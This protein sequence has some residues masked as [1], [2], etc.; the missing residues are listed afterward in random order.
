MKKMKL[1]ASL[2]ALTV[3]M[4]GSHEARAYGP[5]GMFGGRPAPDASIILADPIELKNDRPERAESVLEHPR[6][7][8]DATPYTL[9][10]FEIFPTVEM[11]AT[12]DSNIYATKS[13]PAADLVNTIR[14][15][16]NAFSNWGRH[17]LSMTT[18]GDINLF[19]DHSHENYENFVTDWNGRYDIMNQTWASVRAGYQH[20]AEPR[21]SADTADGT[22]PTTFSV[23]KGGATFYRGL[24]KVK[25]NVDY[26]VKRFD[27]NDSYST[28]TGSIDQSYRDRTE[29]RAGGQ[30]RYD[31]SENFKPF[32]RA[33]Y[34]QHDFDNNET[35]NST[36]YDAAVGAIADLGGVTSI[37]LYAGWLSASYDKSLVKKEV[38]APLVG[39]RIEWNPTG[40]TSVVLEGTRTVEDT[41]L[42][43]FSGYIASGGS[44]TITHELRRNILIEGNFG[45]TRSD[46]EGQGKR[47]DDDYAMGPGVRYL[48]N[49]NI[50]TDVSYNYQT[51]TSTVSTSEF[52][53]HLVMLRLGV[54][55]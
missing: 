18:F 4:I 29:H 24:G 39:G 54:K 51:R 13:K 46:Y 11:G 52:D 22:D 15:V 8:Y 7:D 45:L 16:V 44:A 42:T 10:S 47:Q 5:E 48:V 21:S 35:H 27:Y 31:V 49:K 40:K 17:A 2:L 28:A 34:N 53:K 55:M 41:G 26:D 43:G 9:G 30:V 23:T 19:N 38:Q 6:P 14:P 32:V 50:Y 36:G 33:Y 3:A 1:A 25:A 37:E 12:Y 20:L